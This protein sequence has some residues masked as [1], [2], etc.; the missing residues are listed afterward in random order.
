MKYQAFQ[1]G[2]TIGFIACGFR[3]FKAGDDGLFDL[4]EADASF[5]ARNA[6]VVLVSAYP[7]AKPKKMPAE[8]PKTNWRES[9]DIT[10]VNSEVIPAEGE[11]DAH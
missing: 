7:H 8:S 4:D 10:S 11:Q 2:Q 3:E 9:T 5:L 1:N 6:Q